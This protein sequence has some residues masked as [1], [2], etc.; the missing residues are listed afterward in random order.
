MNYKK[1]TKAELIKD[2]RSLVQKLAAAKK[3]AQAK[4]DHDEKVAEF[5]R[6]ENKKLKDL[7]D[8]TKAENQTMQEFSVKAKNQ[9]TD[10][11]SDAQVSSSIAMVNQISLIQCLK[12][13]HRARFMLNAYGIMVTILI[14][15]YFVLPISII[16]ILAVLFVLTSL[17]I[18]PQ[19]KDEWQDNADSESFIYSESQLKKI[20]TEQGFS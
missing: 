16:G 17:M 18:R 7:L 13:L 2:H 10:L 12:A 11:K 14:G 3:N 20:K 4:K 9:M 15:L 8:R 5:L 1:T 19:L 6:S